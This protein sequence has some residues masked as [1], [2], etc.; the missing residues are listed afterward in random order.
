MKAI[1]ACN[2]ACAILGYLCSRINS[3]AVIHWYTIPHVLSVSG[4]YATVTISSAIARCPSLENCAGSVNG[5]RGPQKGYRIIWIHSPLIARHVPVQDVFERRADSIDVHNFSI[6]IVDCDQR[7]CLA[8]SPSVKSKCVNQLTVGKVHPPSSI[9]LEYAALNVVNDSIEDGPPSVNAC[10]L[11]H[12]ACCICDAHQ[13]CATCACS[14]SQYLL[15][16]CRSSFDHVPIR[17]IFGSWTICEWQGLYTRVNGGSRNLGSTNERGSS[18]LMSG[19]KVSPGS[20][21]YRWKQSW[22]PGLP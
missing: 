21:L 14:K 4:L 10:W 8:E 13:S 11:M 3:P 5:R 9:A 12:E 19:D 20:W 7:Q 16:N 1:V 6:G 2:W 15:N 22:T 17:H 18:G